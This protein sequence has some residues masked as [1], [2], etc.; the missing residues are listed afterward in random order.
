MTRCKKWGAIEDEEEN[1]DTLSAF[2]KLSLLYS[3]SLFRK[4]TSL[5]E[6]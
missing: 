6:S 5:P 2:A 1:G 3:L 4:E